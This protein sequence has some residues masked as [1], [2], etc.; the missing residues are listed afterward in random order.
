MGTSS[1]HCS[2]LAQQT[3]EPW[4]PTPALSRFGAWFSF[5]RE[6]G[7]Q[8]QLEW[9]VE[10]PAGQAL[11]KAGCWVGVGRELIAQIGANES[12]SGGHRSL[13]PPPRAAVSRDDSPHSGCH[14]SHSPLLALAGI[15]GPHTLG[16]GSG[17]TAVVG[18][19]GGGSE[20]GPPPPSWDVL[21]QPTPFA[22]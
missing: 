5:S 17:L 14:S 11:I 13:S 8:P 15:S 3:L 10:P 2:G 18:N 9:A 22:Q 4:L 6:G 1:W 20:A 21:V 12:S 16:A 7:H 19:P